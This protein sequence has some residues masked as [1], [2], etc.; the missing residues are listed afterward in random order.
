MN[1]ELFASLLQS[2]TATK[3]PR[4]VFFSFHY[5]PDVHRA[6]VVRNSWVTKEDR[7]ESGF[8]DSSVFEAKERE[9]EEALKIFLRDGMNGTTVTCVLIGAE[10][11]LR[12]WVRYELVRGFQRGNGLFG[13]RIH[14][15]KN[16]QQMTASPG[17]NPLDHL[18]YRV[19]DNRVY[20]KELNNGT[21][22]DYAKVPSMP[23]SEVAYDLKNQ[24][25]HTF[26][27]LFP[28]YDWASDNGY[29]NLGTWVQRA[30][31]HAGK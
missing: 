24:L 20:W 10:T 7:T 3:V 5:K 16:L 18:A 21:W 8:F 2:S 17:L 28:I 15:I 13:I 26:A 27:T 12:P 25:Y 22:S 11:A 6:W 4:K 31:A 30:A 29:E 23:L 19:V 14:N 1:P 9:S